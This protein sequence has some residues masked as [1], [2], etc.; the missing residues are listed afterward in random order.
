M[1]A[2]AQQFDELPFA[3]EQ[4]RAVNGQ[5]RRILFDELARRSDSQ[6]LNVT[7]DTRHK[8]PVARFVG[9]NH[10]DCTDGVSQRFALDLGV[11]DT[12]LL[13][14][15]DRDNELVGLRSLRRVPAWHSVGSMGM[16]AMHSGHAL[17]PGHI[18]HLA[19]T[20]R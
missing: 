12:E 19:A 6:L 1:I 10:A 18:F 11:R 14:P 7:I 3:A 17:H 9:N 5:Q 4:V 13:L 2:H 15:L 8:L 20:F 16:S